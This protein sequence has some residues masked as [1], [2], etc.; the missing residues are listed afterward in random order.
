MSSFRLYSL[1][2]FLF[3]SLAGNAC[4]APVVEL[5][6]DG[7]KYRGL[8]VLHDKNVCWIA[9]P[10]GTYQRISLGNVTSFR[11]PGGE[12]HSASPSSLA[13]ELRKQLGRIYDVQNKGNF[14]VCAPKGK[15]QA[16]ADV[17]S[18]VERSFNSYFGRR[19]WTLDRSQFPLVVVVHPTRREFDKEV[20]SVGMTP[21]SLLKGFYHPQTN[22]VTL[23]DL[24][25]DAPL[26]P[27]EVA[28][29]SG[30]GKTALSDA[31]RQTVIH[32]TIHQLAFN[33]GLHPRVGNN[34]RWVIEGLAT[35]LEAGALDSTVRSDTEGR[36]NQDRLDWFR[37]YRATRRKG[38]VAD[39]ITNDE[40]MFAANSLDFYSEAWAFTF[41]LAE[42]R[43]ADYVRYLKRIAARDPLEN[44]Y[45]PQQRLADFQAV[46]GKDLR[47]VETQFLRFVDGLQQDEK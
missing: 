17:I 2:A 4:A 23:Y 44:E 46:F 12:F 18:G 36:I 27:A 13:T 30:N 38:T 5:T 7:T 19:G 33:S 39:L 25:T 20:Q 43:R 29:A 26:P 37:K 41:Y 15:A 34:P 42:S 3:A 11:K 24:D 28:K 31:T 9:A 22:R 8:N 32:E 10:D 16:Y 35:M 14:V 47:L 45:T 1:A 40:A 6:A 21:N